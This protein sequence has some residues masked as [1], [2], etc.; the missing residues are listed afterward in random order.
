LPRVLGE[1]FVENILL[2]PFFGLL[3]VPE[4]HA[5]VSCGVARM[6]GYQIG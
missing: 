3:F 6:E 5:V 1:L 4:E 2:S